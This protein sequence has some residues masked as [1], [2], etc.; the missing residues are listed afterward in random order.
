MD[1]MNATIEDVV[2]MHL[3]GAG[4][5]ELKDFMVHSCL[6]SALDSMRQSR[7]IGKVSAYA[8]LLCGFAVLD[9]LGGCYSD[10]TLIP[11]TNRGS[12]VV[13]ALHEFGNYQID[14]P[15]S[16][17]FYAL[18]NSLVLDA[19]L[20]GCT[21][22]GKWYMFRYDWEQEE[23]IKVAQEDWDGTASSISPDITSVINP[24]KFTDEISEIRS[25]IRSINNDRPGDLCVRQS[26]EDILHKYMLWTPKEVE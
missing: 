11:P 19:A 8:P 5:Y 14:S 12:N 10:A 7:G 24:R 18:R 2:F 15:E 21:S 3:D 17:A 23:T 25:S 26:K 1:L 6:E 13:R 4:T 22:R 16:Q 9:Q 20:T